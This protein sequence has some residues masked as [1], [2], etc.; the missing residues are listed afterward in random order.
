LPPRRMQILH[1][2]CVQNLHVIHMTT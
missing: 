1:V 2:S